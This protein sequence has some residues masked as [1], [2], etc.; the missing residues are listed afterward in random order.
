L[1]TEP[2]LCSVPSLS[3]T[4]MHPGDMPIT[5]RSLGGPD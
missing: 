3:H 1:A 4:V 5:L 2:Q